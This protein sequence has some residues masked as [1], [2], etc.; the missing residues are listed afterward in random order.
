[1]RSRKIKHFLHIIRYVLSPPPLFVQSAP[2][3]VSERCFLYISDMVV[4]GY[5]RRADFLSVGSVWVLM[6]TIS[7]FHSLVTLHEFSTPEAYLILLWRVEH[8]P[9]IKR[10]KTYC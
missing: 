3:L 8:K 4:T 5:Y 2:F 1:M 9:L 6:R 10:A 7:L